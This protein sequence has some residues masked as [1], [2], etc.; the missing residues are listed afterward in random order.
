MSADEKLFWR[1]F[2]EAEWKRGEMRKSET[3]K[4]FKEIAAAPLLATEEAGLV[5]AVP[6]DL[7]TGELG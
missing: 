4:K 5:D 1:F 3:Y 7:G 6:E 2:L